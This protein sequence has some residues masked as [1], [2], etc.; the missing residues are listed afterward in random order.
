MQHHSNLLKSIK[1]FLYYRDFFPFLPHDTML[2]AVYAV[3]VC[4]SVCLY[5]CMCVCVCHTPVL[6]QNGYHADKA[7]REPRDTSFLTPKFI[8][9]FE[10][11]HPLWGRQMKVG[12]VKIHHFR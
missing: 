4:L 5:V 12:W 3:V 9:K 1:W 2:S 11:D 10:W 7:T 6:Y 8:A